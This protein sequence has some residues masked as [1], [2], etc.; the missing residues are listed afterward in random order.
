HDVGGLREKRPRGA[1]IDRLFADGKRAGQT[2][3]LWRTAAALSPSLA[4]GPERSRGG[5]HE[6]EDVN[7]H[8]SVAQKVLHGGE[9]LGVFVHKR[10]R[11][12]GRRKSMRSHFSVLRGR[13]AGR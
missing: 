8:L 3:R 5:S 10:Q 6:A 11:G 1:E 4:A 7:G 2:R 12:V 9:L 13:I